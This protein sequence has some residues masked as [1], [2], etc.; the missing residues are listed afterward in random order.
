MGV[1]RCHSSEI[2]LTD[3]L[4]RHKANRDGLI[5]TSGS[6]ISVASGTNRAFPVFE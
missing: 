4:D 1:A 3:V 6:L 2:H 5:V